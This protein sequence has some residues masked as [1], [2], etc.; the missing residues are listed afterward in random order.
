MNPIIIQRLSTGDAVKLQR[1]N[2]LFGDAFHDPESYTS[3]P[4]SSEYL[5]RLLTKDHVIVLVSLDGDDVTGGLVA[6][7]LEKFEQER[8]ELY[9]YDIAVAESRRRC[10]IATLLINQ[11]VDIGAARK[12][13]VVYVKADY[14]DEPAIALYSGLGD[15]AEVLHFDIAVNQG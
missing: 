13:H 8:N 6:Y 5:S 7:E 10:G 14:G 15:R 12:A 1:L 9:I 4:P 2:E 3:R 11:L